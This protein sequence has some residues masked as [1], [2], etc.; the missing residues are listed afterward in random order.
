VVTSFLGARQIQVFSQRIEQTGPWL[1]RKLMLYTVYCQADG[2]FL[3]VDT[4]LKFSISSFW[5]RLLFDNF[6]HGKDFK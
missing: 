1:Q 4:G 2:K 5:Q 6:I 3:T